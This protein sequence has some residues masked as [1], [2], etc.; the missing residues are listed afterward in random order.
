M[1]HVGLHYKLLFRRDL[2]LACRNYRFALPEAFDVGYRVEKYFGA[3]EQQEWLPGIATLVTPPESN[4]PAWETNDKLLFGKQCRCRLSWSRWIFPQ[5]QT[6][7]RIQ[8]VGSTGVVLSFEQTNFQ[9]GRCY[10][11]QIASGFGTTF[12]V[13]DVAWWGGS[14]VRLTAGPVAATWAQY[15]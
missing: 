4:T 1:A 10:D 8:F 2:C 15:P 11:Y 7:L 12:P 9:A 13:A 14:E 5:Q 6:V 3:H